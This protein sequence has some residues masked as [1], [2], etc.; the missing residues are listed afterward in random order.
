MEAAEKSIWLQ[1]VSF[2]NRNSQL[3]IQASN[4]LPSFAFLFAFVSLFNVP[5]IHHC[6]IPQPALFRL[7]L[8]FAPH[9]QISPHLLAQ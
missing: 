5:T 9:H 7:P 1:F 8:P 2:Y 6:P 3:S 4:S